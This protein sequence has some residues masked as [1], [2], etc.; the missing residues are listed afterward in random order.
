[1][2]NRSLF[3]EKVTEAIATTDRQV[4]VLFIDLDDF[5]VVND[6]LGHAAGDALLVS[7]AERITLGIR[8]ADAAAR[9]GGDE[10]ALV[11]DDVQDRTAAV[12]VAERILEV[13]ARPDSGAPPELAASASIG[14]AFAERGDRTPFDAAILMRNADTAMYA[15]KA[16]GKGR[17]AIFSPDMHEAAAYRQSLTR[18][19]AGAIVNG[20][21]VTYF[22]P[23][24]E[25]DTGRVVAAE[26]LLRWMHPTR[27]VINPL[28]VVPLAE[29]T[30]HMKQITETMLRLA[31]QEAAQWSLLALDAAPA[32]TVNLSPRDFDDLD[33]VE[34]VPSVLADA[35]LPP[36]QL[37]IEITESMT[38][39][40]S[41]R[42][43]ATVR[44]L[45]EHGVRLAL[46]DFGTGY[47]SLSYLTRLPLN[48]I[49]IAKPFIDDLTRRPAQDSLVHGIIEL[50]HTLNVA[51]IA[52]GIESEPQ[53]AALRSF[54]CDLGQG[55]LYSRPIAA[56][57]F[58]QWLLRRSLHPRTRLASSA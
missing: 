7:V 52:E 23:I 51:V 30:G 42:C 21:F 58:E 18:D 40:D 29:E 31:C 43:D 17:W 4:A 33:L 24:V 22:Q 44:K 46:D 26:A 16:R 6:S 55:Y 54:G 36:G 50:G 39:A 25:L 12:A 53:V 37:I 2:T 41:T 35:G 45:R 11:L 34:L 10:F 5:K 15:A 20:E 13:L 49:K 1:L 56:P 8:D 9:L 19:F 38:L 14:I 47:S 57:Q 32:V 27:G 48:V 3:L 28:D